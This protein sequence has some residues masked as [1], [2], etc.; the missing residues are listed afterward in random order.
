MSTIPIRLTI[1]PGARL[2]TLDPPDDQG[3]A[4]AHAHAHSDYEL[5]THAG[6][7]FLRAFGREEG[8]QLV[9]A[10]QLFVGTTQAVLTAAR[11]AWP[12][13]PLEAG[14]L[15][16]TIEVASGGDIPRAVRAAEVRPGQ[17]VATPD[18]RN[19]VVYTVQEGQQFGDPPTTRALGQTWLLADLRAVREHQPHPDDPVE[20][21][22][23]DE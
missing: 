16:R 12:S 11:H 9:T 15:P 1:S 21:D 18:G 19:F 4:H 6:S 23:R 17:T 13:A 7:T 2:W 20:V 3:V 22:D 14:G 8:W 5:V 10:P